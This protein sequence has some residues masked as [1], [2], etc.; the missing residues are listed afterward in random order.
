MSG[1]THLLTNEKMKDPFLTNEKREI[2][3]ISLLFDYFINLDDQY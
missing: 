1:Q 3:I 2:Y